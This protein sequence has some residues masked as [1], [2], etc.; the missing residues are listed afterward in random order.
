MERRI[1]CRGG[2]VCHQIWPLSQKQII[3]RRSTAITRWNRP[4]CEPFLNAR[5]A[6][7]LDDSFARQRTTLR[8]RKVSRS[9]TWTGLGAAR[10]CAV[11]STILLCGDLQTHAH[12][13]A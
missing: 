7:K 11:P 8:P 5:A 9:A 2:T 1:S 10:T 13:G 6:I 4:G 12:D 3:F